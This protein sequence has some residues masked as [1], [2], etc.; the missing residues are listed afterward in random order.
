VVFLLVMAVLLA[1][2]SGVGLMGTMSIGVMERA[3]EIGIMRAVGASTGA[4]LQIVLVEG[5]VIAAISWVFAGL[6]SLAVSPAL[7]AAVGADFIQAPLHYTFSLA[8][9]ALWLICVLALA[10][11]A[12]FLPAW[13]AAHL[14]VREVLTYE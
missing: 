6:A 13:N 1:L 2:V 9:A 3:R 5:L 8:G 10:A 14:T 4:V 7:T 11:A 12:S